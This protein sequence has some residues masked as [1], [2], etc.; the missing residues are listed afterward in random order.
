MK[1]PDQDRRVKR[2]QRLLAQALIQLTLD[3]GYDAVTIRD[4]TDLAD[5]GYTTFF[6]HYADK[7]ALLNEVLNVVMEDLIKLL[8]PQDRP[9]DPILIGRLLFHYVE[10]HREVSRVLLNNRASTALVQQVIATATSTILHNQTARPG[11]RVPIE[12]AAHHIVASTL[13]LIEWWL[14][15]ESPYPPEY[16]GEVYAALIF[17]PTQQVAFNQPPAS[18]EKG[19]E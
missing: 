19:Q 9:T 12:I 7:D 15:N 8:Q 16:M 11:S 17:Y 4:I 3:K 2:T 10:G 18:T 14:N 6:R 1:I 5:V 13:A